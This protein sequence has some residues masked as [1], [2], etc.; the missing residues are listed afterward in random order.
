[1]WMKNISSH[2]VTP[3]VVNNKDML[4]KIHRLELERRPA[5]ASV[6]ADR[7]GAKRRRRMW[8]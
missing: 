7:T 8:K 3:H 5:G 1:M 6:M 2:A 4:G